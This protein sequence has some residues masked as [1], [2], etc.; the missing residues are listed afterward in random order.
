HKTKTVEGLSFLLLFISF[1][2]N[3]VALWYATLI[4]Q[5][6]L[7]TKYIL[8]LT[9]LGITIATYIKVWR[10]QQKKN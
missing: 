8:A 10:I 7:Q 4:R 1:I 2:A 6:P 5:L 9:F 3:I